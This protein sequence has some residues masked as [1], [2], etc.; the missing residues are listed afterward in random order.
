MKILKTLVLYKSTSDTM[1]H[2]VG[3]V[4]F[5]AKHRRFKCEFLNLKKMNLISVRIWDLKIKFSSY[6]LIICLHS[7]NSNGIVI[8]KRLIDALNQTKS[9][10]IVFLGNEYKIMPEKITM[11]KSINPNIVISNKSQRAILSLYSEATNCKTIHISLA[12]F[13][14]KEFENC[15][16]SKLRKID[17]GF[18]ASPE[19]IYFGH[20]DRDLISKYFNEF[21][22]LNNFSSNI[23]LN[24]NK[25]FSRNDFFKFNF[26]CRFQLATEGGT[27]FFS[28][29]DSPRNAVNNYLVLHKNATLDEIRKKVLLPNFKELKSRSISTRHVESAMTETVQIMFQGYYNNYFKADIH[30]L[31]VDKGLD[32]RNEILEKMRDV[33][34]CSKL[35]KNMKEL[36]FEK[37]EYSKILNKIANLI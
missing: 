24:K 1:S 18:R 27:D 9:Y 31:P 8:P 13:D 7:T 14:E 5:F 28:L 6:D 23:S 29:D 25:R 12:A 22:K 33:S 15:L 11:V 2:H 16:S 32:N 20:Q 17:I 36:A 3:W 10:K 4:S 30:Y 19:P 21:S 37:F 35:S 34:Y 26:N